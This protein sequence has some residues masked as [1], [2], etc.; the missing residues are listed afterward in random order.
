MSYDFNADEVFNIAIRIEENGAR[1]YRRAAEFQK[2]AENRTTLERLA[3]MEDTH[4]AT[5]EKMKTTL[6]AAEK[7]ATVFDPLGESAQY[8]AAMADMH[9]GEGSPSAAEALTGQESILEIIDIAIGLEKESIL[10]YIGLKDLVPPKLGQD[11]L[12]DIISEERRHIIQLN[13]FRQ[14]IEA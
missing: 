10:F 8:L 1:F 3:A 5:F 9:G 11:K 12:Y 6:S 14:K 13:G 4:K 2:D 7:T